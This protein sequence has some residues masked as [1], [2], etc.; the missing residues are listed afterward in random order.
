MLVALAKI[1]F[2]NR[3]LAMRAVTK[4]DA[5]V[6]T[7]IVGADQ[8]FAMLNVFWNYKVRRLFIK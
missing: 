5:G 7:S 6:A 2:G 8:L 1:T 4:F 3:D